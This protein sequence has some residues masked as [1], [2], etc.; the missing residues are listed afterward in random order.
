MS[1]TK[2]ARLAGFTVAAGATATLVGFAATG[3]GAYFSAS[4][5]GNIAASTGGVHVTSSPSTL[6]FTSSL[7]GVFKTQDVKYSVTGDGP[8]DVYLAFDQ[9]A[10]DYPVNGYPSDAGSLGRFGHL[11]VTGPAGSF[12]SY[13]LSTDGSQSVRGTVSSDRTADCYEDPNT[14]LGGS[15]DQSTRVAD[16]ASPGNGLPT[17][18]NSCPAPQYIL[19]SKGLN[20]TDGTQTAHVTFGFTKIMDDNAQQNSAV[21]H[22]PFRIV[23]EQAGVSPYDPN[24]TNGN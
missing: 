3:T 7:P 22:I 1:K 19:L 2:V 5:D 4:T 18:V 24:T 10:A 11:Q 20:P 12:T 21:G 15:D 16:P 6:D 8:E 17:Y 9:G 23:A 13:N 14:G